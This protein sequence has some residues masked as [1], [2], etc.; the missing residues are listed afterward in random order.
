MSIRPR[1]LRS[2]PILPHPVEPDWPAIISAL[3][4]ARFPLS[5]IAN[6]A[7]CSREHLYNV[8]A[9]VLS[10]SFATGQRLLQLHTYLLE[11]PT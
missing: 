6:H 4:Q 8:S 7:Y 9:G 5:Q 1:K 2:V 3:R 10:P 11:N